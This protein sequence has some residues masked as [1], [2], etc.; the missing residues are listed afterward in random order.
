MLVGLR[1]ESAGWSGTK[2]GACRIDD[3]KRHSGIL[4]PKELS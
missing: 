1:G 3:V 4:R 2:E